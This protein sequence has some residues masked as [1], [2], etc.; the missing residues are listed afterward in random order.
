M[1]N[2]Q[3][4]SG[5]LKSKVDI[6]NYRL[7]LNKSFNPETLPEE[8]TLSYLPRP[9]DQRDVGSCVAM[10][11]AN[12]A[13][14]HQK[15]ELDDPTRLSS[16]F[17][18]G[19]R[20]YSRAPGMT[21]QEGLKVLRDDGIC[22][23]KEFVFNIEMPEARTKLQEYK[24]AGKIDLEAAYGRRIKSYFI[25]KTGDEIKKAVQSY[26][27][28]MASIRWYNDNEVVDGVIKQG[29]EEG[30]LHCIM[31][32]GWN[33]GGWKI[34][35]SWG[36]DWGNYGRAILPYTYKIVEARGVE[37][38]V[39]EIEDKEEEIEEVTPPITEEDNK[40]EEVEDT[41]IEDEKEETV[42]PPIED[43]NEE[44]TPPIE[45]N[46]EENNNDNFPNEDNKDEDFTIVKP[47]ENL[48]VK[49][50]YKIINAIL[51]FFKKLFDR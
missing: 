26:G 1:D 23:Y 17:V 45:D 36:L 35:N 5:V 12:I 41:P 38:Y 14:Y 47:I 30:Y 2:N 33:S 31:I 20:Y 18:Y 42:T 16:G 44:I 40:E 13:E 6:R 15:I 43:D 39:E 8:F 37:N 10:V 21:L 3:S 25:A 46:Q 49:I 34:L 32:Y 28:V 27:P 9:R 22:T 7:K 51:N 4:F 48:L 19:T 29:T 24:D 50:F 11:A